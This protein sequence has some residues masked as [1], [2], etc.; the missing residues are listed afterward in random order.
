MHLGSNRNPDLVLWNFR[1]TDHVLLDKLNRFPEGKKCWL[2]LPVMVWHKQWKE[3]C[4]LEAV[5]VP[6]PSWR[7]VESIQTRA[8][9]S[10]PL[11][12]GIE[13]LSGISGREVIMRIWGWIRKNYN[14]GQP[15]ETFNY[16]E[17]LS[18]TASK[19]SFETKW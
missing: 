12:C 6:S 15:L 5:V 18:C 17:N 11:S 13:W 3:D 14:L 1:D 7:S 19:H 10:V 4:A 2:G 16:V 9:T 8:N